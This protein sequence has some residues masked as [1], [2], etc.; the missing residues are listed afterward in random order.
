MPRQITVEEA[1]E[2]FAHPSQLRGC[3]LESADDLPSEGVEYWSDGPICGAFHK[4]PWPGVWFAHYGVKP[5]GWGSLTAPAKHILT[6]FCEAVKATC[7]IGW[8]DAGNRPAIAFA[9]RIGFRETG[10]ID[11]GRVI[12]TEWR[13]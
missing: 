5:D 1:R 9:K 10:S 4:A 2:F 3:M 11:A 8:T 6:A 13:P 7:V 12:T